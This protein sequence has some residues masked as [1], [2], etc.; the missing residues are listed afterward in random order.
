MPV[1]AVLIRTDPKLE[2]VLRRMGMTSAEGA[3]LQWYCGHHHRT[4]EAAGQCAGTLRRRDG[5]TNAELTILASW[6]AR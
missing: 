6:V 4:I 5:F 3:P 1:Y 2:R